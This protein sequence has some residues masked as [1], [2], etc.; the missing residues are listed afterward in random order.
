MSEREMNQ[1][2]AEEICNTNR[3]NGQEFH[4]GECVGLLD[5]KVVVVANDLKAAIDVVRALDSNPKRGMVFQVGPLVPDL[6]R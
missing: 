1:K 2:V 3:L 4:A 6:I 5:G